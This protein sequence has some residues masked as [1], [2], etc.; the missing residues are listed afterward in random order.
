MGGPLGLWA[1][2]YLLVQFVMVS[3]RPYFLGREQRVVWIGFAMAAVVAGVITWLVMSLMSGALQ[4]FWRLLVQM[5][6]TIAIYPVFGI[7][8][9]QLHRRVIVET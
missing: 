3:Q 1:S 5:A 7:V 4:P 6:V 9:G 8:F 2:V